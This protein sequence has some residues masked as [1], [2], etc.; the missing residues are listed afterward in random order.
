MRKKIISIIFISF[1]SSFEVLCGKGALV[2]KSCLKS[3]PLERV[4]VEMLSGD[5][6]RALVKT[7]DYFEF[8]SESDLSCCLLAFSLCSILAASLFNF[9][10]V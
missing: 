10:L 2:E 6:Y 9:G 4:A 3:F 5:S 8:D 1:I 7:T